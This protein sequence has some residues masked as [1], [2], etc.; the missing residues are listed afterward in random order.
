M[1]EAPDPAAEASGSICAVCGRRFHCGAE[2]G[3][4][5]C[6]CWHLAPVALPPELP[7]DWCLCPDCLDRA[8]LTQSP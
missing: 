2:A 5:D 6:W 3:A 7:A 4:D 1:S 8:R